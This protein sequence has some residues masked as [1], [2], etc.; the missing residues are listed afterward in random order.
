MLG[1]LCLLF[2]LGGALRMSNELQ[3][4]LLNHEWQAVVLLA[5]PNLQAVFCPAL[6]RLLSAGIDYRRVDQL[7]TRHRVTL[8]AAANWP[9]G[10]GEYVPQWFVNTLERRRAAAQSRARGQFQIQA[11]LGARLLKAGV[12]HRFFKGLALG[13]LLYL[14]LAVRQS[15]DIDVMIFRQDLAKANDCLVELGYSSILSAGQA[16]LV[17]NRLAVG[18]AKDVIYAAKDLPIVELHWRVDNASTR[19]GKFYSQ[20]LFN[21]SPHQATPEEFIYLC[22]HAGKT[23]HH[24]L[25]WLVDIDCYLRLGERHDPGFSDKALAIAEMHGVERYVLLALFLLQSTFPWHAQRE[26]LGASTPALQRLGHRI[27]QRWCKD[28]LA[29]KDKLMMMRDRFYLPRLWR[30]RY[31][32]AKSLLLLPTDEVRGMLN[33]RS[34]INAGLAKVLVPVL[35]VR[36]YWRR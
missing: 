14:D 11:R 23:L 4:T 36:G 1:A 30:D 34:G 33:R 10:L 35:V 5:S 25:K 26:F 20:T 8:P 22:W 9:V 3:A 29:T 17:G 6:E 13:Q 28:E 19:F 12:E 18:L 2:A 24:R 27:E 32:I 16:D 31:A 15:N 21:L 7:L